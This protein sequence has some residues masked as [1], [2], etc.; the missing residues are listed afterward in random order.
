[1]L[2]DEQDRTWAIAVAESFRDIAE[3]YPE[4][5]VDEV[6]VSSDLALVATYR[7]GAMD[8]G[9]RFPLDVDP[10][11]GGAPTDSARLASDLYHN[12]HTDPGP[13]AW[14]DEDGRAWWGDPPRGGWGSSTGSE[15]TATLLSRRA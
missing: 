1:M 11:S 3:Q 6:W 5:V 8:I 2:F 7:I 13:Q 12:L 15:R 10:V 9:V 14:V 4:P